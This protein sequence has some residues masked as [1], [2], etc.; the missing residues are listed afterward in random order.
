MLIMMIIVR[1]LMTKAIKIVIIGELTKI[2]I[3]TVILIT[4]RWNSMEK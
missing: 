3:T 4:Y 1:F 2:T